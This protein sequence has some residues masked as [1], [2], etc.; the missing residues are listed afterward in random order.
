V[1]GK[2]NQRRAAKKGPSFGRFDIF[3]T[4]PDLPH[5]FYHRI[6]FV[7]IRLCEIGGDLPGGVFGKESAE[8][9]G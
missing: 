7:S 6:G 9:P 2:E 3:Q 8:K 5:Q 1:Y 4:R